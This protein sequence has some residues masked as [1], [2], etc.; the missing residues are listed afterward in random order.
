M[1]GALAAMGLL[2]AQAQAERPA[3]IPHHDMRTLIR[4]A[5]PDAVEALATRCRPALPADSFLSNEGVGL[6]NRYRA[7]APVDPASA[8]QAIQEATGQNL[9]GFA[10][11]D[12][13]TGLAK[14][15][16]GQQIED[17]VPLKDCEKIDSMVELAG[18]LRADG[19]AEAILLALE[20]A[21]PGRVKGLAV[22]PP[23]GEGAEP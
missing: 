16:V 14:Q 8:R 6:A 2:S 1:A 20:V 5:L 4:L 13:I 18:N 23:K 9:A 10:S 7:E 3:C 12:T 17:H 21:G 22:C 11:D 19:M 15:F